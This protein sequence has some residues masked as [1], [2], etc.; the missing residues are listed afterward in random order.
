MRV[1][2]AQDRDEKAIGSALAKIRSLSHRE[3]IIN[4]VKNKME[5][6]RPSKIRHKLNQDRRSRYSR[7]RK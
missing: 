4:T 5:Y 2:V 3:N 6:R 7:R 1:V